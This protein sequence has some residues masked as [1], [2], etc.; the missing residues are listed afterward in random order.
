MKRQRG[1]ILAGVVGLTVVVTAALGGF[2][3]MVG[4]SNRIEADSETETQLHYAAES[5]MDMG[6]RWLRTYPVTKTNV[7]NWPA[8]P[9]T[10]NSATGDF[11]LQ[12]GAWVKVIFSASPAE[13]EAHKL[14]CFA[15]LGS[16][17]DT[18][19]INYY[20]AL[21][22]QVQEDEG[23]TTLYGLAT[24]QWRETIHPGH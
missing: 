21:T 1:S 14:R 12:D 8:A 13:F 4:S 5:A 23:G 6:L 15:T 22:T 17:R 18:L 16:G 19:E 2:L 24:A 9:I 10:L 7:S 11:T 3:V 20:L